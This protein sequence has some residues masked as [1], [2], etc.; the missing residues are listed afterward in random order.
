LGLMDVI[1]EIRKIEYDKETNE[2]YVEALIE[3]YTVDEGDEEFQGYPVDLC[4][5]NFTLDSE[6]DIPEDP[7]EKC[8]FFEELGL[9]WNYDTL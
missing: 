2:G 1:I 5:A 7:E 4:W 6:E 8:I 3:D 9:N